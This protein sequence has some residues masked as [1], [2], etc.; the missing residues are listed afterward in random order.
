MFDGYWRDPDRT[1]DAYR[2]LWY[3]SGDTARRRP[4]GELEFVDRKS[5]SMRRR[6]ENISSTELE[7]SISAHPAV[8][9]VTVHA[10]PSEQTEDDIKAWIVLAPG[11]QI[12]SAELF[13]YFRMT[14]PYF[15]IP[16]YI[17][18][19]DALPKNA[20]GRVMKHVLRERGNSASTVDFDQ[21]GLSVAPAERRSR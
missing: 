4:S 17:E 21:L 1:L 12:S 20:V 8:A 19:L 16:R 10:V 13:E 5:D 18:F 7:A 15:A 9:D 3:H 6:G 11:P 2:G 14:L